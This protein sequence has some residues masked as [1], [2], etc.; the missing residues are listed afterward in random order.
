MTAVAL[1]VLDHGAAPPNI[2][3]RQFRLDYPD[4]HNRT[5]NRLSA[6]AFSSNQIPTYN[7]IASQL[8]VW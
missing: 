8:H 4:A 2:S 6:F 7:L 1:A 5:E 3:D